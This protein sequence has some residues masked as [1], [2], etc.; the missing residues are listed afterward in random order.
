M[1]AGMAGLTAAQRLAGVGHSVTVLDKGRRP[2]GRMATKNLKGGARADH[3][4]Q[5]FTVR[6]PSFEAMVGRWVEEGAAREWCRGFGSDDGHPRY[7]ATDG[8]AHLAGRLAAGLD[9]RQSVKVDTVAPGNGG[10]VVRWAAGHGTSAGSLTADAVVLT[11]PVPQS[12]ALVGD[13]VPVPTVTYSPTISL[14]VALAGRPAIPAPGGVQLEDDPTWSWI[15]DNVAKGTSVMPAATF[16][17]RND[18]ATDRWLDDED[19]L[20]SRLLSAAAPWLG[21][22]EVVDAAVHR[23]RHASPIEPHP[24]RCVVAAD[25]CVVFAG[26]AFGG[27]RIEGAF[28]S[29][30]AAAAIVDRNR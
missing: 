7:A 8:M 6:S 28:L 1:G 11:A 22:A 25:G 19:N 27:P 24:E 2:G 10:W 14:I 13:H 20:R 3:G 4:A 15:G 12:A 16:H 9:V 23:W 5:F 29:G 17:T 21:T 18:V 30:V 26:D